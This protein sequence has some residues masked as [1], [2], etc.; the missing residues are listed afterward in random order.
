LFEFYC[1]YS[2]LKASIGFNLLALLAGNIPKTS[3]TIEIDISK[4][5]FEICWFLVSII[6]IKSQMQGSEGSAPTYA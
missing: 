4:S 3:N 1:F 2:Y 5:R 6:K